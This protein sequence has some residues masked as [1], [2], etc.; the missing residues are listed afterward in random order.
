MTKCQRA[1]VAIL[2][3]LT[4]FGVFATCGMS[5]DYGWL[6]AA[7]ATLAIYAGCGVLFAVIWFA[8]EWIERG[9]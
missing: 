1:I 9:A 8:V 3:G 4:V 6:G 2:T 7:V 5:D